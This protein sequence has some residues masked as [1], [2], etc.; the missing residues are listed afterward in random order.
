MPREDTA[1][2]LC[3]SG[4]DAEDEAGSQQLMVACTGDGQ[5]ALAAPAV[6]PLSSS[7]EV[8]SLP[9][10]CKLDQCPGLA[11]TVYRNMLFSIKL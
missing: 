2:S 1:A 6:D 3:L 4:A 11:A 10:L 8:C 9:C 5:D 7:L